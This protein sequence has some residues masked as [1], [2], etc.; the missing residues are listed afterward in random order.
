MGAGIALHKVM[1]AG[2]A[3]FS[4]VHIAQLLNGGNADM[5]GFKVGD[6]DGYVNDGFG[7]M[8][9]MAGMPTCCMSRMWWP[10]AAAKRA[11]SSANSWDQ[12]AI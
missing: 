2:E 4:S 6:G 3:V 12:T 7:G 5:G 8:P 1:A 9:G 11:F 10:T